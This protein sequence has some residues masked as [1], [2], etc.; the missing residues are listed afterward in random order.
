MLDGMH[1]IL[2]A[3]VVCNVNIGLARQY[4]VHVVPFVALSHQG[5]S[6]AYVVI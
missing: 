6:R 2:E 1:H 4:D 5:S 3:C